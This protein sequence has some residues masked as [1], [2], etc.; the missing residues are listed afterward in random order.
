MCPAT[1]KLPENFNPFLP[2]HHLK[3]LRWTL[4]SEHENLDLT[5]R[6]EIQRRLNRIVPATVSL[7]TWL[8]L[9]LV[10]LWIDLNKKLEVVTV[11]SG[12]FVW[13]LAFVATAKFAATWKSGLQTFVAFCCSALL[14]TKILYW[15]GSL[16]FSGVFAMART[17]EMFFLFCLASHFSTDF[18][19]LLRHFIS[20][21]C[22]QLSFLFVI[23][24]K[25]VQTKDCLY[26]FWTVIGIL[27]LGGF[28][29]VAHFYWTKLKPFAHDECTR[30]RNQIHCIGLVLFPFGISTFFNWIFYVAFLFDL[31]ESIDSSEN[32]LTIAMVGLVIMVTAYILR[33]SNLQ[34]HL[35][36][37]KRHLLERFLVVALPVVEGW[38]WACL[39]FSRSV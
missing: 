13:T 23:S 20:I 21:C 30:R 26:T 37:L 14:Q 15:E 5:Q 32:A 3:F 22:S 36:T 24:R 8:P 29:V 19:Y 35:F 6:N 39:W 7:I 38:L 33:E 16:V 17:L 10:S 31:P 12:I 1:A 2:H 9:L 18:S 11:L 25:F 34:L 4:R 27:I 28:C